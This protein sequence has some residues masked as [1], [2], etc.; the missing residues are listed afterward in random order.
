MERLGHNITLTYAIKYYPEC[1]KNQEF[2]ANLR[3]FME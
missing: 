2:V 3:K 1:R